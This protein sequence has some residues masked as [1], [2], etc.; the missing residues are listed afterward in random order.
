[1]S[2]STV[3]ILLLAGVTQ[4]QNTLL[5]PCEQQCFG[6]NGYMCFSNGKIYKNQCQADCTGR[7]LYFKYKCDKDFNTCSRECI[8]CV[9]EGLCNTNAPISCESTCPV[10][11]RRNLICASDGRLYTD[12]CRAKCK[13]Q[14]LRRVFDCEFPINEHRCQRRCR[15]A[16]DGEAQEPPNNQIKCRRNGTVCSYEGN[17][18]SSECQLNRLSTDELRYKCFQNGFRS[19]RKCRRVCRLFQTNSCM[20]DCFNNEENWACFEDGVIRKD[21]C[22][23]RCFNISKL[24]ECSGSKRRCKRKCR[25]RS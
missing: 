11:V 13:N 5:T 2:I 10:Y 12:E 14:T 16:L 6:G 15:D 20:R 17:I 8:A 22:Y 9:E 25:R 18:Y 23:A 4:A 19:K 24:F 7:N 1:M 3:L 21:R